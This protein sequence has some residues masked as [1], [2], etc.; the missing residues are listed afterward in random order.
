L[1]LDFVE[2]E[3]FLKL[4]HAIDC[5]QSRRKQAKAHNCIRE[6]DFVK[7]N[8]DN[9][10][11]IEYLKMILMMIVVVGNQR[12]KQKIILSDLFLKKKR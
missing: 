11:L 10:F 9:Y 7:S 2:A 5:I 1:K 4:I 6:F 8:Q 3:D 12:T